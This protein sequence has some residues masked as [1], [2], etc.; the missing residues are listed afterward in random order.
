MCIR[1]SCTAVCMVC[2]VPES[3]PEKKIPKQEPIIIPMRQITITV[4]YTHLDVYKRQQ[5]YSL[6]L[7]D[8][9]GVL[10]DYTFTSN[11]TGL[12]FSVDGNQLTITSSQAIKGLSLIHI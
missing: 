9:N 10:G 1:D 3:S 12:N 4:S 8:T 6:T 2:P 5:Q 11:I 7:T